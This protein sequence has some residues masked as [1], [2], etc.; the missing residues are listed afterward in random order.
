MLNIIRKM[1]VKTTK[2]N[3]F[4]AMELYIHKQLKR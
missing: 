3:T 4:N 2:R 1:Q